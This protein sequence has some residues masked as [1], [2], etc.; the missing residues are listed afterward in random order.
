MGDMITISKKEYLNLKWIEKDYMH[1]R[2]VL[3]SVLKKQY[4]ISKDLLIEKINNCKKHNYEMQDFI[5]ELEK[6]L[7]E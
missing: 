7:I 3:N 4:Y 2:S 5:N 6:L 1:R